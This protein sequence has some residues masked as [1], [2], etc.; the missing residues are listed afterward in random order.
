MNINERINDLWAQT[1]AGNLPREQRFR[2]IEQLTDAYYQASG[3]LPDTAALDRLATL[4]LYEEVTDSRSNKMK[5]QKQ[6]IMS[7]NQY[8]RRTE[9]KH[10]RRKDKEGNKTAIITE[11]PMN[12]TYDYGTD[13][14]NY[15]VPKR[16]QL[17]TDE[18]IE[19]DK[20]IPRDDRVAKRYSDFL[21]GGDPEK[22]EAGN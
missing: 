4:C 1:K 11:V 6:P 21:K 20:A 18:A 9:G 3:K 2:A 22:R 17:S 13:G 7:D 16:R 8:R 10:V 19:M 15:S 12:A 14:R 5:A